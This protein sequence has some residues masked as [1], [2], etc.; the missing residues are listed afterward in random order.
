MFVVC[1][2]LSGRCI[3]DE[4]ITRPE[5][6]F[7]LWRVLFDQETSFYEQAIARAGLQNH[8]K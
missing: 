4:L 6:S 5:E 3:C 2:C 7:R 1:V 8:R